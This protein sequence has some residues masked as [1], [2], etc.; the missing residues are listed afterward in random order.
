MCVCLR[1]WVCVHDVS[2]VHE[3]QNAMCLHHSL[4]QVTVK[5]TQFEI[6]VGFFSTMPTYY[7]KNRTCYPKGIKEN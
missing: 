7:C 6:H 2:S 3:I 4:K 1:A 5:C